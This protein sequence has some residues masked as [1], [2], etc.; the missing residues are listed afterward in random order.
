MR[1]NMTDTEMKL[2]QELRAKRFEG[3]K[4]KRQVPIGSY[5]VDFVCLSHRLVIEVDGSQHDDSD[6]DRRRDAWLE[7]QGFTVL[8]FWNI[9]IFQA[10]DGTLIRILE[11]L[12]APTR[13][14]LPVDLPRE[15]GGQR[16]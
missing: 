11:A 14:A 5:I 13:R 1:S 2:W 3:Y 8:R 6:Y 10:L 4:F 16:N 7:A 9:D 15:G 12:K